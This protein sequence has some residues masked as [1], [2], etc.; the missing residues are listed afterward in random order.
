MSPDHKMPS[1]LV[2]VVLC[3]NKSDAFANISGDR[4]PVITGICIYSNVN[5]DT[6]LFLSIGIRRLS[7]AR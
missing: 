2:V 1:A 3:N 4:V 5:S 7:S 6:G